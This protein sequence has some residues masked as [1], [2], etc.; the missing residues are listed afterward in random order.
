MDIFV[1]AGHAVHE[2]QPDR[3]A[4]CLVEF[5]NRNKR[6]VL[7]PKVPLKPNQQ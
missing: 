6:L 1:D 4:Q 5:W 3:L 7:P 2:D